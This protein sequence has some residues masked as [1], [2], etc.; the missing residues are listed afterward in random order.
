MR[1]FGPFLRRYKPD[2]VLR[3]RY[4]ASQF[5]D[6]LF[7]SNTPW[8]GQVYMKVTNNKQLVNTKFTHS[9]ESE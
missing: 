5:N 3:V 4:I 2:Q 7:S 1:E 9:D 8:R 6:D